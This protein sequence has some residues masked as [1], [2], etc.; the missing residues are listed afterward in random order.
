MIKG[1]LSLKSSDFYN[2]EQ[3][4]VLGAGERGTLNPKH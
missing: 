4:E 1:E 3:R 2:L